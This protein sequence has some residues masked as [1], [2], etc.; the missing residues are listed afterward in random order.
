[1]RIIENIT[2]VNIVKVGLEL[3]VFNSTFNKVSKKFI[4]H[5]NID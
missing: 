4:H 2:E 3:T 5:P 1:M